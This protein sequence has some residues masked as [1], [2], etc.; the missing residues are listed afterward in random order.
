M[1]RGKPNEN[2]RKHSVNSAYFNII[3]TPD[4]AYF[5]GLMM[6]DGC[7]TGKSLQI[8]LID[9]KPLLLL[10]NALEFTGDLY[11]YPPYPGTKSKHIN[12]HLSIRSQELVDGLSKNGCVPK[13][14]H[15][16]RYPELLPE[17]NSHFIRGYFDGDG[18]VGIYSMNSVNPKYKLLRFSILG[19]EDFINSL[20]DVLVEECNI[21]RPKVIQEANCKKNIKK[22]TY[23]SKKDLQ[24]IRDYL[25]KDSEDFFLR[26]KKDIFFLV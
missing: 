3:D 14:T 10:K 22:F 19:N 8:S 5:L 2:A 26:R 17:L 18:T 9:K 12:Y 4:K 23:T 25:Y 20:L 24:I 21:R 13:K 15:I 6:S 7:N 16:L 1:K 11:E